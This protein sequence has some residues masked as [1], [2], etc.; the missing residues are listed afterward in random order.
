MGSFT[1]VEAHHIVIKL[2]RIAVALEKLAEVLVSPS[3]V[4]TVTDQDPDSL[5]EHIERHG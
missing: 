3:T 4:I 2:E 1:P 5:I